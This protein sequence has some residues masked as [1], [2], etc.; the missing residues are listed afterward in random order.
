MAFNELLIFDELLDGLNK[1][2]MILKRQIEETGGD[3]DK[4]HA[5]EA[6]VAMVDRWRDVIAKVRDNLKEIKDTA[7]EIMYIGKTMGG[8]YPWSRANR[9]RKN[10]I[11]DIWHINDC[12]LSLFKWEPPG[13]AIRP[14]VEEIRR[15]YGYKGN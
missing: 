1:L 11:C 5:V 4:L 7:W 2:A 6:E 14:G 12:I 3:E 13:A 15:L 8:T 9:I 10:L